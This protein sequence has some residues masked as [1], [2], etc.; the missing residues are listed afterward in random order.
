MKFTLPYPPS[1]NKLRAIVRNR[2]VT[3][4]EGRDYK[5]QAGWEA[6]RQFVQVMRGPLAVSLRVFRPRKAGDLDNYMKAL[7]DS[8][9]GIAWVDDSQIVEI[10]AYRDEDKIEP[11]VEIE[12][13]PVPVPEIDGRSP[14]SLEEPA[15]AA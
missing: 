6:K 7:F 4:R 1:L 11:R 8:M 13:T 2:I 9:K 10:H 15:P 5:E 14:V 3:T 12:I